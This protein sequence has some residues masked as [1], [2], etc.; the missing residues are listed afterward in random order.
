MVQKIFTATDF[1]NLLDNYHGQQVTHTP[2]TKSINNLS[3]EEILTE[4]SSVTIKCFLIQPNQNWDYKKEGFLEK[5]DAIALIKYAD[6]VQLNSILL[7]INN[8][9]YRVKERYDVKGTY[10]S[11]GTETTYTYTVANLFLAK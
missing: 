7:D 11:S 10:D 8:R 9:K 2:V 3:G 1:E 6:S 4:G 5:G